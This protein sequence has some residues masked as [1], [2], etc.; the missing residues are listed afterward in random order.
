MRFE[1][2]GKRAMTA[3]IFLVII[4][5][6]T[7]FVVSP[8]RAQQA[9]QGRG[10]GGFSM[11]QPDPIDFNDHSAPGWVQIF[12]GK[13]LNG[14]DGAPDIWH[15]EDGAIVG[16]SSPDH[17]SGTTNILWRGGEPGN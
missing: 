12:D 17:P 3:S 8:V 13:T 6:A 7:P 15:V 11:S 16:Q 9:P 1:S 2:M 10:G 5:F 14:W 4:L